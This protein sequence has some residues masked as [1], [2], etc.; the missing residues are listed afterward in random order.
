MPELPEVECVRR[1]LESALLGRGVVSARLLRRDFLTIEP[2]TGGGR[3]PDAGGALLTGSTIVEVK[4]H[5][6]QIA[7]CAGNGAR[8]VVHLGM[9][10]EFIFRAACS[11][12]EGTPDH[13]HARWQ[14]DAGDQLLFRDPRRFGG[15]WWYPSERALY[16]RRWAA[17]GPDAL[18]AGVADLSARLRGSHR[19]VKATLLDQGVIAGVGNIYADEALHLA[20]VHPKRRAGSL[21]A[22]E[23]ERL[24]AAIRGVLEAAVSAG[25]ST[26]RDYRTPDGSRGSFQVKHRVYGR[27]GLTCLAC[28]S[29]LR[30]G[31]VT[32]RTTVWCPSCQPL[33]SATRCRTA[34]ASGLS[35]SFTRPV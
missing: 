31:V 4:R 8:L 21:Q 11:P 14:T 27:A 5:G 22:S 23:L 33:R 30:S 19:A 24:H 6:K 34:S 25:G 29:T 13:V 17:L 35:T 20:G 2:L 9:T 15:L 16:E 12:K 32:Q 3:A 1:G 10:G 7:I 18:T 26:I 28:G